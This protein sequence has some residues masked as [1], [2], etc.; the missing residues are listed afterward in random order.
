MLSFFLLLHL[1]SG[2]Q[3][4]RP[5]AAYRGRGGH[6][7]NALDCNA[8]MTDQPHLLPLARM[9]G[10]CRKAFFPVSSGMP[11]AEYPA[12][13]RHSAQL[14]VKSALSPSNH[15]SQ[16]ILECEESMQKYMPHGCEA[17]SSSCCG[18]HRY[19]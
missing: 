8:W 2:V 5:S 17:P 10:N 4:Q 15:L 19:S 12:C 9:V 16:A 1:H 14:I 11:P 7:D 3:D 6:R 18:Q 13:N